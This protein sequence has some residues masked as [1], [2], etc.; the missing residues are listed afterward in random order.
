MTNQE[1]YKTAEEREEAFLK[2]CNKNCCQHCPLNDNDD[3][4]CRYRWLE[5]EAPMTTETVVNILAKYN[6]WR[7]GKPGAP[8][9]YTQKG[10]EKAIDRAIEIL[11]NVKE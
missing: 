2:F 3:D 8:C 5:L 6:K 1:K 4:D 7:K 9:P 11:Q 10:I